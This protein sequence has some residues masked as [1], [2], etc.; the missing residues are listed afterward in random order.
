MGVM[1]NFFAKYWKWAAAAAL[2]ILAVFCLADFK[3]A[4]FS[5][6]EELIDRGAVALL[7]GQKNRA[8]YLFEQA[9]IYKKSAEG[10][11][12]AARVVIMTAPED[13]PE[14]Q[15][16]ADLAYSYGRKEIYGSLNAAALLCDVNWNFYNQKT[17]GH[18]AE[19]IGLPKHIKK[20]QIN[21]G[22]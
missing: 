1:K 18:A 4:A 21:E 16:M 14:A 13:L 8:R 10:A 9:A 22:C 2:V 19:P 15:R 20:V 7:H 17:A 6:E 3:Y 12:R 11:E 5:S